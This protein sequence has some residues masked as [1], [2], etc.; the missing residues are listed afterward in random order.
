M[1]A[2]PS[3]RQRAFPDKQQLPKLDG[4]EIIYLDGK[5]P[6][7]MLLQSHVSISKICYS[8]KVITVGNATFR[9]SLP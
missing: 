3:V 9:T 5:L 4:K 8:R 1:I 6:V 7:L 2:V